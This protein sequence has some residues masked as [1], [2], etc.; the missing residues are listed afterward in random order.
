MRRENKTKE[1]EDKIMWVDNRVLNKENVGRDNFT[2]LDT[3][4]GKKKKIIT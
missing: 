4:E 1:I 3:N 2:N